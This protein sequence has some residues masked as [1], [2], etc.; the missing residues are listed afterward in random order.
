MVNEDVVP[1]YTLIY[2]LYVRLARCESSRGMSAAA[3]RNAYTPSR[4]RA[5]ARRAASNRSPVPAE[6]EL[7]T[8]V[9][10]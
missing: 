8:T 1:V 7:Q 6:A 9:Q 3:K 4:A 10:V 2:G 5:S